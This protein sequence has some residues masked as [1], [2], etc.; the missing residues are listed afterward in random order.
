[1]RT[2]RQTLYSQLCGS[3]LTPREHSFGSVSWLEIGNSTTAF[4]LK[5]ILDAQGVF[6]LPGNHFYWSDRRQGDTF[7]RVALTRDADMFA[8]AAA[9]LAEVC[10]QVAHG[11]PV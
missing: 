8:E 4:E 3:F 5:Q 7:V 6:V 2:N 11:V 9:L 1:V 10:R